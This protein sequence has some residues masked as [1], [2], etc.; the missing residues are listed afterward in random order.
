MSTLNLLR[1]CR[2][3]KVRNLSVT[4][5]DLRLQPH[6]ACKLSEARATDDAY[7][8]MLQFRRQP[9]L[10]IPKG[11]RGLNERRGRHP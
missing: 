2:K 6:C 11:F 1:T 8:G 10:Y 5:F 9:L 3:W 7:G 4:C